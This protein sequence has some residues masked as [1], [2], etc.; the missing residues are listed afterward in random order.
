MPSLVK[1][2]ARTNRM[3]ASG[4]QG[5]GRD[6]RGKVRQS[7]AMASPRQAKGARAK[8]TAGRGGTNNQQERK[9]AKVAPN[10][11]SGP[12]TKECVQRRTQAF[13]PKQAAGRPTDQTG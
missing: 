3:I 4:G 9:L 5:T 6:G 8:R 10:D 11:D 2:L 13:V 1:E 12:T 7:K